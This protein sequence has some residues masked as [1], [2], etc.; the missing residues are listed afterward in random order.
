MTLVVAVVGDQPH[1]VL[2]K[3]LLQPQCKGGLAAARAADDHH[4]QIVPVSMAVC[5]ESD[6]LREDIVLHLILAVLV[7]CI[8]SAHTAP[9]G[10]AV[11]LTGGGGQPDPA[12]SSKQLMDT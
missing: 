2:P 5:A 8:E 11:F 3:A 7:F 6:I 1:L 12:C 9:M 10:R 4:I